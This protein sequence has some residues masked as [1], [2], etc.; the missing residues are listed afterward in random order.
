M[1]QIQ[2]VLIIQITIP[3]LTLHK[4]LNKII[5]LHHLVIKIG[6]IYLNKNYGMFICFFSIEILNIMNN[7]IPIIPIHP[8]NQ[9]ALLKNENKYMSNKY[10]AKENLRFFVL[11]STT[12]NNS[13]RINSRSSW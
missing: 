6:K 11:A 8:V 7:I 2:T 1:L 12:R 13:N 9:V 5:Y 3:I 4:G 10:F